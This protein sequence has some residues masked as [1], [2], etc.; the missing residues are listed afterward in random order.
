MALVFACLTANLFVRSVCEMDSRAIPIRISSNPKTKNLWI[1]SERGI[2][3]FADGS[4]QI[5]PFE[6]EA[7]EHDIK[8]LFEDPQGNIWVGT[9]LGIYKLE[10]GIFN[11]QSDINAGLPSLA[12]SAILEDHQGRDLDRNA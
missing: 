12:V 3:R 9:T 2:V 7:N 5:M 8:A 1:G 4:S 11:V 10:N 6:D